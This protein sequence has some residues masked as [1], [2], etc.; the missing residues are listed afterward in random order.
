MAK[1]RIRKRGKTYSYIFEAGKKPDGKRKV[2]EKG[3]FATKKEA[4]TAGVTAYVDWKHGSIGI[5]S[6][7][8]TLADFAQNWLD[9]VAIMNV[10]PRTL[11]GYTYLNKNYIQP[12]LGHYMVQDITPAI[13]DAWMR[14]LTVTGYA[15]STLESAKNLLHNM[16]KYAVFPAQ[17]ISSNPVSY[18]RVPRSA[19]EKVIERKI[20]R[21]DEFQEVLAKVEKITRSELA[22]PLYLLYHT[23]MRIS[24]VAGLRWQDV[25]LKEKTLTVNRTLVQVP[26]TKG[27]YLGKLKTKNSHRKIFLDSELISVLKGWKHHQHEQE[28]WLDDAYIKTYVD[29]D[30]RIHLVSKRFPQ[31]KDTTPLDLVCTDDN[32]KFNVIR[33]KYALGKIGYNSHSF[34]HSHATMLIEAG[35]SLKGVAGRLGHKNVSLTENL[36]THFTEQMARNTGMAFEQ[37]LHANAKCRQ[38]GD[39][40]KN[41]P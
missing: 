37:I 22:I 1:V 18:I 16:L 24:E 29:A 8:I 10:R 33:L 3:G 25:N 9:N 13:L 6:E 12:T 11:V 17:I 14:K 19:P 30:K 5:T 2:V 32:G 20:I 34:R 7:R 4:Y 38:D 28:K 21:P 15:H 40:S 39:K 36:Y 35:A 27:W 31:P 41:D 23:G 26:R